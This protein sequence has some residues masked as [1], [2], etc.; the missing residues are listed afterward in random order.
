MSYYGRYG[1]FLASLASV[2]LVS[3]SSIWRAAHTESCIVLSDGQV[4]SRHVGTAQEIG[5]DYTSTVIVRDLF[6]KIPVRLKYRTA[7]YAIQSEVVKAFGTLKHGL[8]ALL[9][10]FPAS[11]NL[12]LRD[13]THR[14]RYNHRAVK[15]PFELSENPSTQSSFC[16]RRICSVISQAGFVEKA[17]FSQWK[18]VSGRTERLVVRAGISLEPAA[19]KHIQFV[20]IGHRPLERGGV[21]SS[22]CDLVNDLFEHSDFG[23]TGDNHIIPKVA[24]PRQDGRFSIDIPPPRKSRSAKSVDKWPMFY[25]RVDVRSDPAAS[26]ALVA[27]GSSREADRCLVEI[28]ELTKI[29]VIHFLQTHNFRPRAQRKGLKRDSIRRST[30][31]SRRLLGRTD[32]RA[33]NME[34]S[35]Y[36]TWSRIKY[37]KPA[38]KADLQSGM[39][40]FGKDFSLQNNSCLDNWQQDSENMAYHRKEDISSDV[41]LLLDN[42]SDFGPDHEDN[43]HD[44]S[45]NRSSEYLQNEKLY[46][47]IP[48]TGAEVEVDSRTGFVLPPNSIMD[49]ADRDIRRPSLGMIPADPNPGRPASRR[50]T[51]RGSAPF[52]MLPRSFPS[53]PDEERIESVT[54]DYE[55][56][57]GSFNH[58][59]NPARSVAKTSQNH[60][61]LRQNLTAAQVLRQVDGKFILVLIPVTSG[62]DS[63]NDT[64]PAP[65]ISNNYLVLI[66]QH[67]ADERV[68]VEELYMKVCVKS[69]SVRVKPIIMEVTN[70][71]AAAFEE[72]QRYF[73]EWKI[74]YGVRRHGESATV[75]VYALPDLIAERCRVEPKVLI[76]LL[77][78]EIWSSNITTCVGVA[79]DDDP[80]GWMRK[81]GRCP[82]GLVDLLNSR[83]C[84]SAVMFNDKLDMQQCQEL[85]NRLSQCTF[86]FQCA[87]GRPS[88]VV[89]TDLGQGCRPAHYPAPEPAASSLDCLG[90][91]DFGKAWDN[92]T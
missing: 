45:E 74:A 68:K 13:S 18:S 60:S 25:I 27:A 5:Y 59:Y 49:E 16:V 80:R 79:N 17:S 11:V 44:I 63:N 32:V 82:R 90:Q 73:E 1:R 66:D 14:N 42:F 83:A 50:L 87:H 71:E 9:L 26:S 54:F 35:L 62:Q 29:L 33:P 86:P 81:I 69:S 12:Q 10:A 46:W 6:G 15:L 53:G 85:V 88:M 92:W 67:A 4:L 78:V 24:G 89:I 30:A 72:K 58:E 52:L 76:D 20:S 55:D 51:R 37:A 21:G 36:D 22:I 39:P 57:N 75:H 31:D 91:G 40:S 19:T 64:F 77:R 7:K 38:G 61:I 65:T 2:S 34:P 47:R 28:L 43:R 84:R 3:I 48:R 56:K 41:Q 23:D 8:V 70:H